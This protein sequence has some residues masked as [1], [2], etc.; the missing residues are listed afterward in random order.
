MQVTQFLFVLVKIV[1]FELYASM[2]QTPE[3]LFDDMENNMF[4]N[5]S[6]DRDTLILLSYM[7]YFS[8]RNLE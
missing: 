8:K 6:V 4:L 5:V 7:Q 3:F 2:R 1:K